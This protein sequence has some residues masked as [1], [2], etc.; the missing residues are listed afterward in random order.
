MPNKKHLADL[1]VTALSKQ[2]Q[3]AIDAAKEAHAAAVDDQ[4]IA[5]TQ[6]DTLAIE[7][8]YLAEGQ[9][10]RVMEFQHAIK[11]YKALELIEF[12]SDSAIVL[13]SLVQLSTDSETNHWFFIGPAAGGF[14]CQVEQ[15]NITVITP[16]SPMG[17]ALIGKQQ[18]DDIEVML[19]NNKLE[20][21][22]AR[23]K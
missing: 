1:I 9:S 21:Y 2:L 5:E 20:D 19:G 11:A 12:N 13:G 18:D 4:S 23:C 22:I 7:A 8:S 3:Q 16:K 17:I 15:Q 6:Y 10:K 14:R